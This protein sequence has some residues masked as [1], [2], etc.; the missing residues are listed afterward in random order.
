MTGKHVHLSPG[1]Q[2]F[3][4][5][6]P[7]YL[8]RVYESFELEY[9][10]HDF[11]EVVYVE[12]GAGFHYIGEETLR[13][14]KGELF[15]LPVGTS[16][17]F[18]PSGTRHG[19]RLVVYNCIY[20]ADDLLPLLLGVPGMREL[21]A[22]LGLLQL[23]GPGTGRRHD[24]WSRFADPDGRLGGLLRSMHLEFTQREPGYRSRIFGQFV[25]LAVELERYARG[26]GAGDVPEPDAE[27]RI[28]RAIA[29]IETHLA[30]RFQAAELAR[31]LQ[32]SERHFHRLFR[33]QT[34][35]T[36]TRY[37]QTRR[38]EQACRLLRS[39]R[40]TVPAIG[41]MVGYQDKKFFLEVFKRIAGVTPNQYRSGRLYSGDSAM[42]IRRR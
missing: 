32:V 9:H 23:T 34:G 10:R 30:E 31:L 26:P 17:V 15:I 36:L 29:Y 6:F 4:E 22:A 42:R 7:F 38:V 41:A 8:N 16:H 19:S 39:T 14:A 18:R 25:D 12:E 1:S 5:G 27:N 20:K 2:F 40:H 3:E 11:V 21:S 28:G 35:R 13:V 33:Q 24:G 37:V